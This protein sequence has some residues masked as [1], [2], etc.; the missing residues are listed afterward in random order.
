MT[1][2]T[3]SPTTDV[4]KIMP[5]SNWRRALRRFLANPLSLAGFIILVFLIL[6]AILA[7]SIVPFPEDAEGAV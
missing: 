4:A 7:P 5:T 3:P 6:I 1:N 2:N